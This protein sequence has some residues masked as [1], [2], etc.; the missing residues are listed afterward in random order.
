MSTI[1]RAKSTNTPF[2]IKCT[3]L[4]LQWGASIETIARP[5]ALYPQSSRTGSRFLDPSTQADIYEYFLSVGLDIESR[6]EANLTPILDTALKYT[7]YSIFHLQYLISKA[8]N[9]NARTSNNESALHLALLGYIIEEE[10]WDGLIKHL[11]T[12]EYRHAAG[13]D[14]GSGQVGEDNPMIV[15]EEEM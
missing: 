3:T 15:E 6:D 7:P 13:E 8:A 4:L 10:H 2:F 11:S 1:T 9:V 14:E 12:S 5:L